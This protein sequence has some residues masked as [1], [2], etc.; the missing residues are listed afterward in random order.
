[1]SEENVHGV[2][3]ELKELGYKQELPRV[4]N[5]LCLVHIAL[6]TYRLEVSFT[7]YLVRIPTT[8]S[9]EHF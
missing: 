9:Y 7:S 3:T 2:Q 6:N 1:M 5:V 4:C 8:S